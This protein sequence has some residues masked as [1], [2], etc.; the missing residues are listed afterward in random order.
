MQRMLQQLSAQ[1][2]STVP[3]LFSLD[4][5]AAGTVAM[6]TAGTADPRVVEECRLMLQA[7]GCY[8]FKL[9][10]SGVMGMHRWVHKLAGTNFRKVQGEG[11]ACKSPRGAVPVPVVHC[12]STKPWRLVCS[13]GAVWR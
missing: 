10:E 4:G 2:V 5:T 7:M 1:Q 9:A 8:S 6:I 11:A 3:M 12:M 13:D